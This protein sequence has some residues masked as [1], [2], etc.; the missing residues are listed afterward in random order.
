MTPP[1]AGHIR[2]ALRRFVALETAADRRILA[3][4]VLSAAYV[5]AW[6]VLRGS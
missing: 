6:A 3:A 4:L 1:T 5:A 2:A